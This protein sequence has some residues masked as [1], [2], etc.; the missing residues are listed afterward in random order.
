VFKLVG[1]LF[2]SFSLFFFV[3]QNRYKNNCGGDHSCITN[4]LVRSF[5]NTLH[6]Y[7]TIQDAG[8]TGQMATER[9]G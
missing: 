6:K 3:K 4:T 9:I 5:T 8:R 2:V 1:H 7:Q